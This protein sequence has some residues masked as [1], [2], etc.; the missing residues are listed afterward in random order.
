MEKYK[1]NRPGENDNFIYTTAYHNLHRQLSKL[2]EEKGN[3]IHI[4][5][6]PGTGKSANIYRALEELGLSVYET[7]LPLKKGNISSKNVLK[8]FFKTLKD[9][10]LV[11]SKEEMYKEL[12]EYDVI[13]I[14]DKFHDYHLFNPKNT[15]FS[16]WTRNSW[17]ITIKFYLYCIG[18]YITHRDNF[19][20]MNILLQT[21]WRVKKGNRELDL[22]TEMGVL[23]EIGKYLFGKI[24][25]YIEIKYSPEEVVSIV[26][27]HLPQANEKDIYD[28]IQIYGPKPRRIC[29]ALEESK[30]LAVN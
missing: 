30:I 8:T 22:L 9:D 18:E 5:G 29:K 16:Q 26:L 17:Y 21:S 11:K 3:I 14:A 24:F 10:L 12:S 7:R 15:G 19:K 25:D 28:L 4:I 2:K 23:S 20:N 27:Q 13:L 1:V 6:A